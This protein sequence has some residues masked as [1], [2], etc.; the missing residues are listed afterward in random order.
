MLADRCA[1]ARALG[2]KEVGAMLP[3][4]LLAYDRLVSPRAGASPPMP[5]DAVP[6]VDRR[7]AACGRG[8]RVDPAQHRIPARGLDLPLVIVALDA[9]RR[10]LLMLWPTGQTIFHSLTA[11][12]RLLD[13]HVTVVRRPAGGAVAAWLTRERRSPGAVRSRLVRLVSHALECA[14]RAG[15]GRSACRASRLPL[16]YRNVLGGAVV[17]PAGVARGRRRTPAGSSRRA[18][19]GQPSDGDARTLLRNAMW[20]APV[21]LWRE[22]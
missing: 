14:V 9:I 18:D 5:G 20:A 10:Y 1:L 22:S 13:P 15:P 4:V 12:D 19:R 16:E 8:T 11:P 2:A 17:S 21:R 6:A 7:H 3:V